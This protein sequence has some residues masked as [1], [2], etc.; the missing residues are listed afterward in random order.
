MSGLN[1]SKLGETKVTVPA[2]LLVFL[3]VIGWNAKSFTIAGLDEFFFTDAA[4]Q[5]LSD[6]ISENT[7]VLSDYIRRQEIRDVNDQLVQ[8]DA[9][10]TETRLWIAANGENPI[11]TARLTDLVQRS[12][13]LGDRK[14]CLLNDNI[15][16]KAVCEDV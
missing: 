13:M 15:T 7:R 11:A 12:R 2:M 3:L 16:D 4:A 10:V 8:V 9:Q 5:I 6:Q 14:A 1:F